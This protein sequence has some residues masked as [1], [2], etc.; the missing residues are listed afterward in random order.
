M[1]FNLR[2]FKKKCSE[3]DETREVEAIVSGSFG[4]NYGS[5][6]K[7]TIRPI[8]RQVTTRE[9]ASLSL[10]LVFCSCQYTRAFATREN[11]APYT[12]IP[13]FSYYSQTFE[14]GHPYKSATSR[15]VTLKRNRQIPLILHTSINLFLLP[16]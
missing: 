5:I 15:L 11:K 3:R 12:N 16:T 1:S 7:P 14:V 10:L 6:N 9:K 2:R 8:S 13:Q 4:R